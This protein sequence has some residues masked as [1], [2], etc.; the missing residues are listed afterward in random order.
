ML[1]LL[2]MP[3]GEKKVLGGEKKVLWGEKKVLWGEECNVLMS[4]LGKGQRGENER[5]FL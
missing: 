1:F 5:M 2:M 3:K 4:C